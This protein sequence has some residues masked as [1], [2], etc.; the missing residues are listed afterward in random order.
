MVRDGCLEV[1][2]RGTV[3]IRP[4]S[5]GLRERSIVARRE[6]GGT[7]RVPPLARR[8]RL[9]HRRQ[10]GHGLHILRQRHVLSEH[11][12]VPHKLLGRRPDTHRAF[13]RFA[14]PVQLDAELRHRGG[15]RADP[16]AGGGRH[17]HAQRGVGRPSRARALALLEGLPADLAAALAVGIDELG[18]GHG[19]PPLVPAHD[20]HPGL[21]GIRPVLLTADIIPGHSHRGVRHSLEHASGR[22]LAPALDGLGV[23]HV[24]RETCRRDAV[25]VEQQPVIHLQRVELSGH[26]RGG[27]LQHHHLPGGHDVCAGDVN[28]RMPIGVRGHKTD[29]A[30]A[31]LHHFVERKHHWSAQWGSCRLIEWR[32][33]L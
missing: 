26:Q 33:G 30:S 31:C 13:A 18:I 21:A 27:G 25:Q 10:V 8:R 5:A 7:P 4:G 19:P 15:G 32:N 1:T 12:R 22:E 2:W 6:P 16:P 29:L 3:K 9:L 17:Q 20:V 24:L 11:S 28:D 14:S 23:E